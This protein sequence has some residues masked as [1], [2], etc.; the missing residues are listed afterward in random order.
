MEMVK[1]GRRSPA[2]AQGPL[3]RVEIPSA[4][5]EGHSMEDYTVERAVDEWIEEP[6]QAGIN[7][8]PPVLGNLG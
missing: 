5:P 3:G 2:N 8:G 4:K 6:E 1:G 7:N